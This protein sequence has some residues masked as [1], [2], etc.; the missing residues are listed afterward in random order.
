MKNYKTCVGLFQLNSGSHGRSGD[1]RWYLICIMAYLWS[2]FQQQ[3]RGLVGAE[4]R[5]DLM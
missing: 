3:L 1:E 2:S 5:L 4:L